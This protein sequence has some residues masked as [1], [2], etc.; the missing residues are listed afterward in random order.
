MTD[1]D[2]VDLFSRVRKCSRKLIE[3]KVYEGRM[4]VCLQVRLPPFK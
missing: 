2:S 1:F 4:K 3:E